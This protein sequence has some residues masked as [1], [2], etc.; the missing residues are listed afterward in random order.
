MRPSGS[1]FVAAALAMVVAGT[2]VAA[3]VR[4]RGEAIFVGHEPIQGTIRGHRSSLPPDTVKCVNCHKAKDP[5][6]PP[7]PA[8]VLTRSL[9]FDKIPRRGGP[10]SS[11]DAASFCKMLRSG[12]DPAYILISRV[13]PVYDVDDAQCASLWGFLT[14]PNSN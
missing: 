2:A 13:M 1:G 3:G 9:L 4:E 7:S 14:G 6:S 12:I 5:Q 11:Y 8:P 10:P